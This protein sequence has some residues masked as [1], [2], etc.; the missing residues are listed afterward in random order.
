MTGDL[1]GCARIARGA[2]QIDGFEPD[3]WRG[4]VI[5][6]ACA[7]GARIRALPI[8]PRLARVDSVHLLSGIDESVHWVNPW[9]TFGPLPHHGRRQ[10]TRNRSNRIIRRAKATDSG[11]WLRRHVASV[12]PMSI[13]SKS[14]QGPEGRSHLAQAVRHVAGCPGPRRSQAVPRGGMPTAAPEPSEIIQ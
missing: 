7:R 10:D 1:S 4:P 13:A 9:S 12:H 3:P 14:E 2:H 5:H 11:R 8:V 6:V